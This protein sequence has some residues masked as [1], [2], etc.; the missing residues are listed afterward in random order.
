MKFPIE[1]VGTVKSIKK[2]KL[3]NINSEREKSMQT[4]KPMEKSILPMKY[5]IVFGHEK[6]WWK[7]EAK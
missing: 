3:L 1:A 6:K 2:N 7:D 4:K 5:K